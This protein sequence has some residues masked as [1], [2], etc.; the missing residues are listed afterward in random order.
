[1]AADSSHSLAEVKRLVPPEQLTVI[2]LEDGLG[3]NEL[4]PL[5]DAPV[6]DVPWPTQN[7]ADEFN[8]ILQ[9]YC[10]PGIRRAMGI[11]SATVVPIIGAAAWFILKK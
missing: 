8:L 6:P 1:M 11:I 5:V 7:N 9:K 4:C 10:E 2:R 3:W